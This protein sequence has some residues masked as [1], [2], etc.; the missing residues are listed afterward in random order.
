MGVVRESQFDLGHIINE[1]R[2]FAKFLAELSDVPE[3]P[4]LRK[5]EAWASGRGWL[6]RNAD[7]PTYWIRS[8]E[9]VARIDKLVYRLL[10]AGL[11]TKLPIG[12]LL[13][14]LPENLRGRL[15]AHLRDLGQSALLELRPPHP[16]QKPMPLRKVPL[17]SRKAE[18]VIPPPAAKLPVLYA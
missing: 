5:F 12:Q 7:G 8:G 6:A 11:A 16:E 17:P 3:E 2:Q 14:G 10:K 9:R 15:I 13:A 4:T 1:R 18:I